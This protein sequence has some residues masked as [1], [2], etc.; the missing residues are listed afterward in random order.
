MP[1]TQPHIA[2]SN[3]ASKISSRKYAWNVLWSLTEKGLRIVAQLGVGIWVARYLQ[4]ERFGTLQYSLSFVMIIGSFGSLGLLEIVMRDLINQS[5]EKMRRIMGTGLV[6][7]LAGALVAMIVINLLA[8]LTTSGSDIQ[9][10]ILILSVGRLVSSFDL[11]QAYFKAKVKVRKIA[12]AQFWSLMVFSGLKIFLVVNEAPLEHFIYVYGLDGLISGLILLGFLRKDGL[13]LSRLT[14]QKDLAH[15]LLRN[16]LPLMMSAV[17]IQLYGRIDQVLIGIFIDETAV[18]YYGTAARLFDAWNFLPVAICGALFPAIMN[19]ID[20]Q[21][22]LYKRLTALYSV[23]L[24]IGLGIA[25]GMFLFANWLVGGFFGE[26]YLPAVP[27]LRVLTFSIVATFLG[28]AT[29]QYLIAQNLTRISLLRTL[30]GA[31]LNILLNL[32]MIPAWGIEGA[33]YATIIS[34]Y[35]GIVL[36]LGLFSSTRP[37]LML[38]VRSLNPSHAIQLILEKRK[39]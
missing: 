14:F 17:M 7:R 5:Q 39:G 6:L 29:E 28:V 8:G 23:N 9:F 24:Y 12:I 38:L 2:I 1:D 19:Q 21:D 11:L 16:S 10:Y 35:S 32:F 18:G 33:A 26:A 34:Y 15:K 20:D 27:A 31:V 36:A 30:L 25:L 13:S 4:P 3:P 22:K 37:Q